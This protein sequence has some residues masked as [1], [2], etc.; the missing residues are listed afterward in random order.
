MKK[1]LIELLICR[2]WRIMDLLKAGVRICLEPMKSML[3]HW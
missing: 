2:V 3:L 1:N